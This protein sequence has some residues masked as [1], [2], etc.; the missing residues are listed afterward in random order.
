MNKHF[1]S[2]EFDKILLL[3]KDMAVSEGAKQKALETTPE[4][5]LEKAKKLIERT[6]DAFKL[7]SG[8]STPPFAGA[9]DVFEALNRA[10]S[11]GMLNNSEL[12]RIAG[13]LKN[14]TE[15]KDWRSHSENIKTSLDGFFE[16]LYENKR[17]SERILTCIINDEEISDNASPELFS[18]RRKIVNISNGIREKLEKITRSQTTQK[19]C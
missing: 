3:L 11:G 2:L 16:N 18:I 8:F 15:L 10:E 13:V 19:Y 17:L 9:K 4:T 12:L 1:K 14:V 5:S 7:I 6:D